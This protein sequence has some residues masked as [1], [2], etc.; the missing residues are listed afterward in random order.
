MNPIRV[1]MNK[2][3]E[4][5]YKY[6]SSGGNSLNAVLVD[7]L[8]FEMELTREEIFKLAIDQTVKKMIT[9]KRLRRLSN[10]SKPSARINR[11]RKEVRDSMAAC[12]SFYF[13]IH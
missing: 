8:I 7:D 5:L 6:R 1:S 3:V 12:F 4:Y 9:P 10:P 11:E 13:F 2:L